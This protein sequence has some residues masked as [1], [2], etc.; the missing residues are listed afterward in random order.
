[1]VVKY[2]L[3]RFAERK[4]DRKIVATTSIVGDALKNIVGN[5]IQYDVIM[6]YEV[7]PHKY[8]PT[9]DDL[10]QLAQ[11]DVIVA[12]GLGLEK[13]L[14]DILENAKNEKKVIFLS[15][16]IPKE[17]LIKS[18]AHTQGFD[19]HI[20]FDIILW[21]FSVNYLKKE[22][23]S[24][25]PGYKDEFDYRT[26][27]Y[28]SK[29]MELNQ[30][31]FERLNEVSKDRRLIL[32]S[33]DAYQYFARAF[34]FSA[35]SVDADAINNNLEELTSMVIEKKVSV[36]FLDESDASVAT[37]LINECYKNNWTLSVAKKIYAY[38]IDSSQSLAGSYINMMKYNVKTIVDELAK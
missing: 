4:R 11:A 9:K 10:D 1:M 21:Q 24:E 3:F 16:G 12:N 20:W 25:F 17:A 15:D 14:Q 19:P 29:L 31:I 30:Q 13:G 7:D 27:Q 2:S 8:V 5:S 26:R 18:D 6:G 22:L 33:E 34:D 23:V 38:S 37:P 35:K 28:I 32:S 36:I